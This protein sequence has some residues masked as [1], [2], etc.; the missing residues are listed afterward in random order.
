MPLQQ[1]FSC[2]CNERTLSHL[3]SNPRPALVKG[4]PRCLIYNQLKML[5]NFESVFTAFFFPV[6]LLACTELR[7]VWVVTVV[8]LVCSCSMHY[9]L[10][11]YGSSGH[12]LRNS[13]LERLGGKFVLHVSLEFLDITGKMGGEK[14]VDFSFIAKKS[15]LIATTKV[16]LGTGLDKSEVVDQ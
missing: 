1:H 10:T 5:Q 8:L 14:T 16:F 13:S 15:S 11:F 4:A 7:G 12:P 3:E 2:A 9:F 6:C